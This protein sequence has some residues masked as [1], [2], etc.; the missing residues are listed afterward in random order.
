M[1]K[2]LNALQNRTLLLFLVAITGVW[3]PFP[4]FP[5]D[6]DPSAT[7]MIRV[8]LMPLENLTGDTTLDVLAGT[9][10][11]TLSLNLRLQ[12]RFLPTILEGGSPSEMHR[13][14]P[15]QVLAELDSD[16]AVYISL[17]RDSAA[18]T[19]GGASGR[20]FVIS[21]QVYTGAERDFTVAARERAEDLFAVFD[22]ADRLTTT[23]LSGLVGR[24][25]AY[26]SLRITH[27][28]P[29]GSYR[30]SL[31]GADLGSGPLRQDSLVTGN[32]RLVV[33]QERLTEIETIFQ[34][35]V[36][37]EPDMETL[38][39]VPIPLLTREEERYLARLDA[40]VRELVGAGNH[41][42]AQRELER[43]VAELE[44]ASGQNPSSGPP[45]SADLARQRY[46]LWRD[47]LRRQ[48]ELRTPTGLA[49]SAE[50][51]VRARPQLAT[52]TPLQPVITSLD[53]VITERYRRIPYRNIVVD[54]EFSD[55]EGVP[56]L[57]DARSPGRYF[58]TPGE[59][60]A[61]EIEAVYLAQDEDA[62][63]FRFVVSDGEITRDT[64]PSYKV[65]IDFRPHQ[66][67]FGF[68]VSWAPWNDRWEAVAF[69]WQNDQRRFTVLS[70]GTFVIAGNAVEARFPSPSLIRRYLEPGIAYRWIA[71]THAG[72]PQDGE[73]PMHHLLNAV[74]YF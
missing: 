38:V 20:G 52:G 45:A 39:E 51:S 40:G 21:A 53:R 7:E 62:V 22:A 29:P 55:W 63:Y 28:G 44:S 31:G 41:E 2:R 23:I 60:P 10:R 70:N 71:I 65:F 15:A 73:H 67:H 47:L 36:V 14:T 56:P 18:A 32:H 13:R 74:A 17:E 25:I 11:N 43:I 9:I 4:A 66:E 8:V 61:T 46:T 6:T 5:E 1:R 27:Q 57:F 50:Q 54:G 49:P 30:V 42:A 48:T 58:Q 59:K 72:D 64:I 69:R 3:T 19:V 68:Q 12:G 33:T 35:D 26:G 34:G 37:I 16:N 24:D